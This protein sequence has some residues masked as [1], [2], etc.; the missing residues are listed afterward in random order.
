MKEDHTTGYD[1]DSP[2]TPRYAALTKGRETTNLQSDT[3]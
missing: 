1:C 3:F 2:Q